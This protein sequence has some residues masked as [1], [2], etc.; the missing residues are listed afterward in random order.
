[1]THEER[2]ELIHRSFFIRTVYTGKIWGGV[3]VID[4]FMRESAEDILARLSDTAE[5]EYHGMYADAGE[6]AELELE[7]LLKDDYPILERT[8]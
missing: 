8:A 7:E 4:K 5:A 3:Q 6:L 2:V 1:M